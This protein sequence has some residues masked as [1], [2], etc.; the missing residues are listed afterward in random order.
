M[1]NTAELHHPSITSDVVETLL[2]FK[3]KEFSALSMLERTQLKQRHFLER[4]RIYYKISWS[5]FRKQ[6]VVHI[7]FMRLASLPE[8]ES[9]NK[10]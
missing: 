7:L 9:L 6:Q 10:A 4:F 1:D 2:G 3:P 8:L 5:D